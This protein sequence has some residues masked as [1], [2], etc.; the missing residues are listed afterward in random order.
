VTCKS[1]RYKILGE[2]TAS[3]RETFFSPEFGGS[4]FLQNADTT[5]LHRITSQKIMFYS[6]LW[7]P[8]AHCR[9]ILLLYIFK[10]KC[11]CWVG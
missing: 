2:P 6:N 10:I 7:I 5:R 1:A 8:M 11:V 3:F 9:N 4:R